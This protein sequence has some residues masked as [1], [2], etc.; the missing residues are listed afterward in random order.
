MIEKVA[1]VKRAL[2]ENGIP[3]NQISGGGTAT[4]NITGDNTLWTEIQAGSYL[5]M[6]TEY[7]NFGL[8]FQNAL[9]VLTTVIH[10]R[11]SFAVTD[12]G[13]KVCST[14]E[15]CQRLKTVLAP[16]SSHCMRSTG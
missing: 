5:F 8:D 3:V 9:T 1:G 4:Y 16:H 7:N 12:A 2:E 14:M 10:K 13:M 6:D 15:G 11:P